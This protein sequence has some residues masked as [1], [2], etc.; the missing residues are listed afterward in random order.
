M[1]VYIYN[2]FFFPSRGQKSGIALS[3][4]L[5]TGIKGLGCK[6]IFESTTNVGPNDP[7]GSFPTHGILWFSKV[8]GDTRKSRDA[9]LT[10]CLWDNGIVLAPLKS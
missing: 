7:C 3:E 6:H 4:T 8:F 10:E 5:R 2:F 1:C 9:M